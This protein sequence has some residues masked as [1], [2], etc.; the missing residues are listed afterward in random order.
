MDDQGTY[1]EG[2]RRMKF[3]AWSALIA[4]PIIVFACSYGPIAGD[5]SPPSAKLLLLGLS[6]VCGV[7]GWGMLVA[8]AKLWKKS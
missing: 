1:R 6:L 8:W 2:G 3:P 4:I 5:R 7:I